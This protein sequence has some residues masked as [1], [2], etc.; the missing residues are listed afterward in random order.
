MRAHVYV[1][2][3]DVYGFTRKCFHCSEET[4]FCLS[5]EEYVRLFVNQEHVQDVFPNL[6]KEEREVMISGTHPKCWDEM[7]AESEEEG[8]EE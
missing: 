2:K 8:E 5:Y 1:I 7:F 3:E 6:G 4:E